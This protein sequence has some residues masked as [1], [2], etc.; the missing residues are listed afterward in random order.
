M[1]HPIFARFYSLVVARGLERRQGVRLRRRLLDGLAGSVVEVG[2]GDGANFRH[3]PDT[4]S[5]VV[6]IEPESYL[7]ERAAAVAGAGV[8]VL[9]GDAGTLPLPDAS[10]DAVVFCLV[11]CSV[12]DAQAALAEAARV[13]RPGGEL[14]LLEHVQAHQ[15]GMTRRLQAGLDATVWPHLFGG[16]HCGRDT[17]R[18]V[19]Q[20]GF[21]FAELD[22]FSFPDG[23][24]M[25]MAPAILGRAF[26]LPAAG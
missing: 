18:L 3:Y 24:R 20:A 5:R 12:P 1:N 13:L 25:P 6:A 10:V 11:L 15:P 9:D 22:R 7:R 4:V 21:T 8:E 2:A 19:E 17:T 14:R 23:S 26:R 16:C